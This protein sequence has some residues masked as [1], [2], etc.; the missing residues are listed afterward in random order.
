[1]E[2]SRDLA[3]RAQ[4]TESVTMHVSEKLDGS[5]S[6]ITISNYL[7]GN[8]YFTA[9][10]VKIENKNILL[11]EGKHTSTFDLPSLGD[12]KD[13]LVKMILFTNLEDVTVS[14]QKM[15]SIA[16]LKMTSDKHNNVKTLN[17]KQTSAFGSF[18]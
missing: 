4:K 8:Y 15:K 1:M 9:D 3:K 2:L 18:L 6:R 14:G 12:I 13:G 16:V 7:G 5:K 11:I 10:E 17:K